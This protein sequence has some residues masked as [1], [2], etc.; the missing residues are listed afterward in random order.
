PAAGKQGISAFIVP[1]STPGYRVTGIETK[2]GQNLSDTASIAFEDMEV[3]EELRPGAEGE[4][5]RIALSN[6]EGGRIGIAAQ[7]VG[8]ARDAFERSVAYARERTSFGRPLIEHQ[9]VAFRLAD[10]AARIEGAR[11]LVHHA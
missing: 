7:S 10:M 3:P 6:L 8:M 9:A 1:T 4:G 5:Y 2:L 11:Q